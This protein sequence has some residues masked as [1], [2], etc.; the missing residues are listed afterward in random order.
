MATA[1]GTKEINYPEPITS[2]TM[3]GIYVNPLYSLLLSCLFLLFFCKCPLR[4]NSLLL[5]EFAN[6][7]QDLLYG[8]IKASP[9]LVNTVL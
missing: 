2:R 9:F 6:F 1:K 3:Q 8:F 7:I 5:V 4:L